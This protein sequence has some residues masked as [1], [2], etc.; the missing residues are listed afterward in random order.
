MTV[1]KHVLDTWLIRHALG[2]NTCC[3]IE[4]L[5]RLCRTVNIHTKSG[6]KGP[7][8]LSPSGQ[9]VLH[10]YIISIR[11]YDRN[12]QHMLSLKTLFYIIISG[13]ATF[14]TRRIIDNENEPQRR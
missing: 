14:S 5:F 7:L 1:W 13:P 9:V 3:G 10:Y 12:P 4:I 2:T 6:I 8:S 11:D